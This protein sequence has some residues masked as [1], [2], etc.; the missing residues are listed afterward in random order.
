MRTSIYLL[1]AFICLGSS[2]AQKSVDIL[3]NNTLLKNASVSVLVKNLNTGKVL[4]DINSNTAVIPASTMKIVTTASA[5]ELLGSNYTINTTLEIDGKI[6]PN[7]NL[8]GNLYINGAGDP[9]LGSEKTGDKDFL[10]KWV[11]ALK[12]SG[13]KQINGNIV[14]CEGCFEKQIINPAWTW[15]D[16]GNYYAP[17]IHGISYMDNTCKVVFQSGNKG[18]TPEII[19]TEPNIPGLTFKN[20]LKSSSTKSDNAYFYGI[21]YVNERTIFGEI[22]SNRNEFISKT[23]IPHP[24]LLLLSDFKKV[25]VDANIKITGNLTVSDEKCRKYII[26]TNASPS[27]TIMCDEINHQSNNHYAEYIFK[28]ISLAKGQT[29]NSADSKSIIENFW[30]SKSLPVSELFQQDGCGLAPMNAVSANFFVE[31]LTYMHKESKNFNSFY[32]TLPVSGQ[33]GTLKNFLSGTSLAGRVHAKSGT[34][35]RVKSYT[36]YIEKDNQMLVFAV[37]INN[38]AGTSRE[39]T[40][41]IEDFLLNVSNNKNQ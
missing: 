10:S 8:N 11:D 34:I 38:A 14:A 5:F 13:I 16:M 36:G 17:G 33:S 23:D 24:A 3:K 27:L 15:E 25:L 40:A 1:L 29:G 31:L 9:T 6:D 19:R 18:S 7:G 30:K 32:S 26:Y 4:A 37:L 39:V 20:Y 41:K 21:P 28:Q 22:P 35:S 2:S 12:A